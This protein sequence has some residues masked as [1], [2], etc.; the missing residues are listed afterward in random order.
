MGCNHIHGS[1]NDNISKFNLPANGGVMPWFGNSTLASD[2]ASAV[3]GLLGTN[4]Q[5]DV[6]GPY[7]AHDVPGNV[8]VAV[9]FFPNGTIT[10]GGVY[11]Y[12]TADWAQAT[13]VPVPGPLPALGAA[14]AFGF[15]R[16]LRK[17][18]KNSSNTLSHTY[19]N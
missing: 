12:P 18:I 4:I 3:G 11:V 1:Y 7:F 10:L 8:D 9:Y 17:R 5:N 16:Q 13:R 19:G 15:S 14:A 6:F 2:F